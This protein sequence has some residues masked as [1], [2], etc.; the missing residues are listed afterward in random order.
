MKGR[1]TRLIVEPLQ[2][3]MPFAP[4]ADLNI[5]RA[6]ESYDAVLISPRARLAHSRDVIIPTAESLRGIAS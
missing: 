4:H 1:G 6:A 2:I 3:V 5:L